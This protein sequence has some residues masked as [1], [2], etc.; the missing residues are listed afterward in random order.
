MAWLEAATERD[1]WPALWLV[2]LAGKLQ[3][4]ALG[5]VCIYA[6]RYERYPHFECGMFMFGSTYE[7]HLISH[8]KDG[9][10]GTHWY[11]FRVH[12]LYIIC[13]Y[14]PPDNCKS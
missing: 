1:R 14:I 10:S 6:M 8:R 4:S 13:T 3:A 9:V 5:I 12:V 7:Y 2:K 11:S